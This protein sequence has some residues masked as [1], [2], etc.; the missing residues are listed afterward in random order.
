MRKW[1]ARGFGGLLVLVVLVDGAFTW[2]VG[3]STVIG[4][5]LYDQR[6]DGDLRVGD[7]APDVALIGLAGAVDTTLL[8]AR[9]ADRPLVVVFGSFT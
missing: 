3:P 8:A 9:R 6:R 4:M 5:A 7:P 2:M 1:I